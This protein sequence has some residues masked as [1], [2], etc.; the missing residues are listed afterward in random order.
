MVRPQHPDFGDLSI[1]FRTCRG[2][3]APLPG[4]GGASADLVVV[5]GGVYNTP[6]ILQRSGIGDASLLRRLGVPVVSDLPAVGRN[7][8]DHPGVAFF[9]KADGIAATAGRMLATMW[10]SDADA[11]GEP[12]WQT[13]PFPVDEEEGICGFWSFL[14]REESAGTVEIVGTDPRAAPVIDHN[15]LGTQGD[16]WD[17]QKDMAAA[18]IGALVAM[19]ITAAINKKLQRDFAWEWSESLRVKG[20]RPLGEDEI[21]RLRTNH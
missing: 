16:I 7:L 8:T 18:G 4:A 17:A 14:C 2:A 1:C 3:F 6:A 19:L 20:K 11:H 12:W 21:R 13:H 9:Y 5:A 15:Y 10:R